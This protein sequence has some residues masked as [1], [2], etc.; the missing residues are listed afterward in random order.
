MDSGSSTK[1]EML[2]S[3]RVWFIGEIFLILQKLSFSLKKHVD[4]K[5]VNHLHEE[6]YRYLWVISIPF[7]VERHPHH[8]VSHIHTV[9]HHNWPLYCQQEWQRMNSVFTS[10]HVSNLYERCLHYCCLC[11]ICSAPGKLV[12]CNQNNLSLVPIWFLKILPIG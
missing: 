12:N 2:F 3:S 8:S 7:L 9:L 10:R 4:G 6:P 5:I 11:F 1:Q